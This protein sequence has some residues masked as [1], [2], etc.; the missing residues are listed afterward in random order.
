MKLKLF[1]WFFIF[2]QLLLELPVYLNQLNRDKGKASLQET[3]KCFMFQSILF[4]KE[5]PVWA[6]KMSVVQNISLPKTHIL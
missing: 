5:E 4:S 2:K 3:K 6:Y 1:L